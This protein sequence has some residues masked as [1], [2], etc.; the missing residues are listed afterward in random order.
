MLLYFQA[1]EKSRTDAEYY[2]ILRQAEANKLLYTPE[3]LEL[4]RVEA[5]AANQKI[6]FGNQLP[7]TFVSS[8]VPLSKVGPDVAAT[9][10]D[11]DYFK[12]KS[13]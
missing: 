10:G 8:E 9:L 4:K 5:L 13:A 6:Y 3:Y 7:H 1:Q 11:G 2:K 12:A